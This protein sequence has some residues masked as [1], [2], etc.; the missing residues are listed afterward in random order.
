MV[1]IA[2]VLF[3]HYV[4]GRSS[5]VLHSEFVKSL[6]DVIYDVVRVFNAHRQP[7]K[8]GCYAGFPQLLL[9]Q[10]PVCVAGRMQDACAGVGNV[11]HNAH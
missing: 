7:H 3:R 9:R 2:V 5:G 10:L 8:V 4:C 11:C 1:G 6:T